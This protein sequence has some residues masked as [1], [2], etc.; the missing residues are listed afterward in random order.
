LGHLT[1]MT[2]EVC[3]GGRVIGF[4]G[5][6]EGERDR[7]ALSISQIRGRGGE[8]FYSRISGESRTNSNHRKRKKIREEKTPEK[9]Y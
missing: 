3:F 4:G 9:E 2:N 1:K 6:A 7:R 5:D 8:R